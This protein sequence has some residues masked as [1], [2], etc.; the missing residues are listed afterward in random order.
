MSES[1]SV[2]APYEL[3]LSHIVTEDDTPA[4]NSYSEKLM[5][6]LGCFLTRPP[7]NKWPGFGT[8]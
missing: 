3:D 5:R 1:A 4:D 6:L 7:A 2:D 8:N